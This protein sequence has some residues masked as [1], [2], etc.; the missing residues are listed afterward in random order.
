MPPA[1]LAL[2]LGAFAIGTSEFVASGLLPEVSTAFAV[3]IPAAGY[4]STVY[5]LSVVVGAP[6]LAMLG[7]RIARQR[8][9]L[10]LMGLFVL[11]NLVAASAPTFDVLL[12]GRVLAALAH[13]AFFGIGS[14]VAAGLVAPRRKTA[15]IAV[16]FAGLG[17]ANIAGVPLGTLLAQ[18]FGWRWTFAAVTV[19]GLLAMVGVSRLVPADAAVSVGAGVPVR[20]EAAAFR[21]VQVLLAMALAF[22]SIGA[23]FAT[24][25]YVAPVLTDVAGYDP[26]SVVWLLAL[27]GV[28][29]VAGNLLG[30]HLGDR[31]LM[32]VLC[33]SL[34]ALTAALAA[35]SVT[36]HGKL[37]AAVT[38]VLIGGAAFTTIPTTQKR[39]LDLAVGAPTLA[40][41]MVI[42]AANAGGALATWLGGL[43][44]DAGLDAT[45]PAWVGT[46][47]ASSAL[48]LA[49]VSAGLDRRRIEPGSTGPMTHTPP[50]ARPSNASCLEAHK[51][52]GLSA[53]E[54]SGRPQFTTTEGSRP[55]FQP[56]AR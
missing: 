35:F 56:S 36:A 14:I 51:P 5:A 7:A 3:S 34:A 8:I 49:L 48:V 20:S 53:H 9:L 50:D 12:A 26:A 13:S 41:A 33:W 6:V 37:S 46:G 18:Q 16:M 39:V 28:G 25:T 38:L 43:V 4:L 2:S 21:D 47:L 44:L 30:G 17:A 29:M 24:I 27:L 1:L 31:A 40:S 45:S 55:G 32:P 15:A 42:A 23:L 19:I 11:G 54:Y 10:G 52:D 22:L